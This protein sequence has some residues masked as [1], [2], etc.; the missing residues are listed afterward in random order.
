MTIFLFWFFRWE[1]TIIASSGVRSTAAIAIYSRRCS[2][3]IRE[4]ATLISQSISTYF[5]WCCGGS[6]IFQPAA[7]YKKKGFLHCYWDLSLFIY[8]T[9][10]TILA[11]VIKQLW[12]VLYEQERNQFSGSKRES[13]MTAKGT[14]YFICTYP[15]NR[16]NCELTN[17]VRTWKFYSLKCASW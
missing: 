4:A 17:I 14:W 1:I 13:W 3:R 6:D 16:W 5:E 11:T 7:A 15:Y 12:F 10:I 9:K 8:F 2:S